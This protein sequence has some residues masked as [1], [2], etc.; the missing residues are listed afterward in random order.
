MFKNY[1][2]M[3]RKCFGFVA[4]MLVIPVFHF[5]VFYVYI[6]ANSFVLAFTDSMGNFT[7]DNFKQIWNE[8]LEPSGMAILPSIGRSII[9]WGINIFVVF[10][11]NILFSY[12]LFK[13]V[14]G[15]SVFRL[16]FLLP[17]IIGGVVMSTMYRYLMDG[18]VSE[19][20]YKWGWIS[21]KLY[22]SGFFYGENSF[23]TILAY[24]IWTGLAGNV[25]VLTGALTR[26]P[27]SVLEAAKLDGVGFF[28]EFF[29]IILPLIWPSISTLL[30]YQL[31]SVFL[32]DSGTYLLTGLGNAPASTGGYY[33]FSQVYKITQSGN[34]SAVHYPAAVGLAVTIIT[35][36]FVLSIRNFIEKHVDNIEY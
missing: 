31:G 36:P 1:T 32:A 19:L 25:I 4:L 29:Q 12:A 35:M 9:T 20:F 6:N 10:P 22:Q 24:G 14:R 11:L 8:I 16:M 18:G 3:E 7:L 5:L 27:D 33:I 17:G 21:E 2:K 15:A 28:R 13:K 34:L 23:G 26:I 30:I